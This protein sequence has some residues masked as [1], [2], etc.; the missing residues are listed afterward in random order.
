[1]SLRVFSLKRSTAGAFAVTGH[2][3]LLCYVCFTISLGRKNFKLRTQNRV[4]VPLR[5]FSKIWDERS[6][7]LCTDVFPREGPRC[8]T[9]FAERQKFD[10]LG[11]VADC[12]A[13]HICRIATKRKQSQVPAQLTP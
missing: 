12:H 6:R 11:A 1:M 10:I 5:G 3:L 13:I 8:F 4:L 2:N 9:H 7:L